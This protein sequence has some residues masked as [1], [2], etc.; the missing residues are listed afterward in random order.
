[1]FLGIG[2]TLGP[3]GPPRDPAGG[4]LEVQKEDPNDVRHVGYQFSHFLALKMNTRSS[5]L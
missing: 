3:P 4:P 5:H 2:K 1:M